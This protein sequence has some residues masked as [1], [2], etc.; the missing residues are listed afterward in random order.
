MSD[1][2]NCEE[3]LKLIE[4][5]KTK[6]SYKLA[7]INKN[8]NNFK[9]TAEARNDTESL[10]LISKA[11]KTTNKEEFKNYQEQTY[12]EL[13]TAVNSLIQQIKDNPTFVDEF[14][15]TEDKLKS[16]LGHYTLENN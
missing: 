13:E 6:T 4:E 12:K 14:G 3:T 1:Y 5:T 9:A 7:E 10:E 8:I 2:I 11:M 15:L 16:L